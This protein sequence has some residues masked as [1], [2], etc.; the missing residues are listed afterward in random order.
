MFEGDLVEGE[1]EIGQVAGLIQKIIPAGEI[2]QEMLTEFH[3]VLTEQKN[4]L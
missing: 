2:V 4:Y 3:Q 1:L